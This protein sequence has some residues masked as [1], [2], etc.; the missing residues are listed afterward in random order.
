MALKGDPAPSADE[1]ARRRAELVE[2]VLVVEMG[3][4]HQRKTQLALAAMP[5]IYPDEDTPQRQID[6]LAAFLRRHLNS[7]APT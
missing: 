5:A 1:H 2:K 4:V 6:E 3:T 7:R